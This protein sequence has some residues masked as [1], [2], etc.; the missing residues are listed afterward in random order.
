[1]VVPPKPMEDQGEV[2]LGM[3]GIEIEGW[4][5]SSGRRVGANT[6]SHTQI[7]DTCRALPADTEH[8]NIG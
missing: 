5:Q 4:R 2:H 7:P 8:C 6:A 3:A 1:M